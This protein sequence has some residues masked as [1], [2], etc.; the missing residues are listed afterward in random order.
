MAI[1]KEAKEVV[2]GLHLEA[3]PYEVRECIQ[4]E[5]EVD[6]TGYSSAC[7]PRLS[8]AQSQEIVKYF[9]ELMG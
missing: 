1:L 6:G 2:G 7:D 5:E 8:G 4:G 9:A 3:T